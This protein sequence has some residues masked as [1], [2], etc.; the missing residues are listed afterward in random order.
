MGDVPLTSLAFRILIASRSRW[1]DHEDVSGDRRVMEMGTHSEFLVNGIADA[2][3]FLL[4]C[5]A[6]ALAHRELQS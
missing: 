4:L 3:R 6:A 2:E 5:G 1:D